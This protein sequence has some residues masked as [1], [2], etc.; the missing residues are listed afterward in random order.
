M[1][2]FPVLASTLLHRW[3]MP[4][5]HLSVSVHWPLFHGGHF[6][7][8]KSLLAIA[9]LTFSRASWPPRCWLC[10]CCCCCCLPLPPRL[11]RLF[12]GRSLLPD[13]LAPFPTWGAGGGAGTCQVAKVL[14]I[15]RW[16]MVPS[17]SEVFRMSCDH[18]FRSASSCFC[19]HCN[20][21][22]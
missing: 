22:G 7:P 21:F 4:L 3:T 19:N 15:T 11:R 14:A 12:V 13:E 6:M 16:I 17:G 1:H 8:F 5:E 20:A 9:G 2:G 18:I 10:C